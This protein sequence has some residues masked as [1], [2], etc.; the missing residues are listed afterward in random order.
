M[1]EE[2]EL[3]DRLKQG[4][5]VPVTPPPVSPAFHTHRLWPEVSNNIEKYIYKHTLHSTFY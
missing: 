1:E 4:K 3:R 2:Q 5:V